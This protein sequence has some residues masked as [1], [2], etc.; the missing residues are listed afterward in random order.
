MIK[1]N[2]LLLK[3][4]VIT[5]HNAV[6]ICIGTCLLILGLLWYTLQ[7]L[8]VNT[9][10]ADMISKDL[11]WR[12]D[13]LQYKK[14]FPQS[15]HNIILSIKGNIPE[16]VEKTTMELNAALQASQNFKNIYLLRG[17]DFFAKQGL[18][19]LS[20][21][22]LQALGHKLNNISPLLSTLASNWSVDNLFFILQHAPN[23]P[24]LAGISQGIAAVNA[25]QFYMLSWKKL[26]Q[27]S[28][29][30][31]AMHRSLIFVQ[32]TM[33]YYQLLPGQEAIVEIKQLIKQKKLN[34]SY[35]VEV[36]LTGEVPLAYE[37]L[38]SVT[39]GMV[40]AG[41]LSLAMVGIILYLT[42]RSFVL[43]FASL[44]TL[45]F[46]LISTAS[47]ATLA[48]GHLNMIS[49]AFA[50]LYIG[51]G[52]DFSIHVCARY[53]ELLHAGS[54]KV[55]AIIKTMQ[56][57]GVSLLFC[58]ITTS[59]G[60]YAF[61]PTN[62]HGVSELG[63]ISGTGM[64]ISFL[65]N[66][67]FLPAALTILPLHIK[68]T[69]L[70]AIP[71]FVKILWLRPLANYKVL[72]G[73]VGILVVLCLP[74]L[75]QV[76]FVAD[77]MQ[78]RDPAQESVKTLHE[79]SASGTLPLTSISVIAHDFKEM[80]NLK[81]RLGA[82]DLV[83]HSIAID[84]FIPEHQAAKLAIIQRM[85]AINIKHSNLPLSIK[86]ANLH[87]YNHKLQL[88][89]LTEFLD[90]L[91]QLPLIDQQVML[92]QLEENL[93]EPL[94]WNILQLNQLLQAQHFTV[95]DLPVQLSR[96]WLSANGKYKIEVLPKQDLTNHAHVAPFVEQVLAVAPHATGLPV[97]HEA[98]GE[99]IVAS[100]Q[101]AFSYAIIFI[102]CLLIGL[103]RRLQDVCYVLLPL[104]IASLFTGIAS[105][106]LGI[107]FNFA[108]IIALPL[109]L[110][111]GVDNGIHLVYYLRNQH[112]NQGLYQSSIV[113]AIVGSTFTTICSF[114]NL[115]FSAHLGMASMGQLL[116]IGMVLVLLATLYILPAMVSLGSKNIIR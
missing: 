12:Q 87:K 43:M 95:A 63:L 17:G 15:K 88:A 24:L 78:L 97:I 4:A 40:I 33:N 16:L 76:N 73:I 36:N 10:T 37:E 67:I 32:P 96:R 110:G 54:S 71:N 91:E 1:Y 9:D 50:V 111:I 8:G 108:N 92:R 98:A 35:G 79:L 100:F 44:T 19:Y 34:G 81:Q 116:V 94:E 53:R 46:G 3:L 55:Q 38:Q 84:D 13:Y 30:V 11:T 25:E 66:I 69:A 41:L 115:A 99:V 6:F 47:F 28:S 51:L 114:G 90:Q 56:D 93:L 59:A 5:Q 45:I 2:K 65:L 31:H 75:K 83:A 7:N 61:L 105:V 113:R 102:L 62:F 107:P 58:A 103:F 104:L 14:L 18:L 20:L 26:L 21:A 48:V 39:Q 89:P 77:P 64:L 85:S 101:Q 27:S 86:V 80:Q 29:S 42:L 106:V 109:L 74:L 72:L 23:F 60:F 112:A 22:E 70:Y 68:N 57:K 49:V 82:L 52:I